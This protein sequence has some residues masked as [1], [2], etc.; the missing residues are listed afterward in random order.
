MY[1]QIQDAVL[2]VLYPPLIISCGIIRTLFTSPHRH[3]PHWQ[4]LLPLSGSFRLLY[5]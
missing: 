4:P 2:P 5:G 3:Q 1:D